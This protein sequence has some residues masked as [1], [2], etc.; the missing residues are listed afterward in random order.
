MRRQRQAARAGLA[1]LEFVLGIPLLLFLLALMVNFAEI[2]KHKIKS[3][4]AS[5][6]AV[7]SQRTPQNGVAF[8]DW[9]AEMPVN[10]ADAGVGGAQSMTNMAGPD[11]NILQPHTALRGPIIT[12]V[13]ASEAIPVNTDLLDPKRDARAGNAVLSDTYPL[14]PKLGGYTLTANDP[15]LD[16]PFR[17]FDM[18]LSGNTA[19]RIPH[20]YDFSGFESQ[21]QSELSAYYDAAYANVMYYP[22]YA[23][24]PYPVQPLD[25]DDDL[26]EAFGSPRDFHRRVSPQQTEPLATVRARIENDVRAATAVGMLK[27]I[28]GDELVRAMGLPED[29]TITFINAYNTLVQRAESEIAALGN[30]DPARTAYLEGKIAEWKEYLNELRAFHPTIPNKVMQS[31]P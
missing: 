11:A 22:P 4:N 27:R 20:I 19:L 21:F 9:Y 15:L 10:Q 7:W 14:L 24:R 13:N 6:E 3:L 31:T 17:W 30:T 1:P 5:R 2:S 28:E 26:E 29:M 23:G 16:D 8:P 25:D 12:G 18:G